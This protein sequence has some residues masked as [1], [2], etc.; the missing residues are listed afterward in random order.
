MLFSGFASK[1][2]V[3]ARPVRRLVVAIPRL[4]GECSEKHPKRMGVSAIFGDNR[5]LFPF[6]RGIATP[7]CALARNDSIFSN[8]NLSVR[9]GRAMVYLW[10][11]LPAWMA[12]AR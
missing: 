2:S 10:Y 9:S 8:T 6:N 5:Y 12:S 11:L 4:E 1:F 7:V 3:I